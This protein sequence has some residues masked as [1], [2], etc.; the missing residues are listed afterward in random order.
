MTK[1]LQKLGRAVYNYEK[2]PGVPKKDTNLGESRFSTNQ[3]EV[4]YAVDKQ[5]ST[6]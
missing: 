1:Y 3:R 6:Q 2:Q 5:I 4:K